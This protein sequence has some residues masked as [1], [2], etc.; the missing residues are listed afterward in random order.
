M[1]AGRAITLILVIDAGRRLEVLLQVDRPF[2]RARAPPIE[3]IEHLLGDIDPPLRA[4]LLLDEVHREHR[5]QH[6]RRYRLAVRPERGKQRGRQVRRQVIP[7]P[8]DIAFF[9]QNLLF[10]VVVSN[11]IVLGV[12]LRTASLGP[13]RAS[14]SGDEPLGPNLQARL[15]AH[16]SAVV[17]P[18]FTPRQFGFRAA[19]GGWTPQGGSLPPN[20][21]SEAD[22]PGASAPRS[23]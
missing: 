2:Q 8:R 16:R 12:K 5:G 1:T 3:Y 23:M 6:V 10:H 17:K 19:A 14:G 15:I 4:D 21:P 7:L 20:P 11:L 22:V 13:S 9:Q 18:K